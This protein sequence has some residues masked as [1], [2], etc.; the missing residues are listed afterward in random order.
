MRGV[1]AIL[2]LLLG[3]ALLAVVPTPTRAGG[4][5]A[6]R[7]VSYSYAA[8]VQVAYSYAAPIKAV[9]AYVSPDYA[10]T[11]YSSVDSAYQQ[12]LLVDAVAGR[13]VELSKLQ[14]ELSAL[15]QQLAGQYQPQQ[16]PQPYA[17]QQ[18]PYAPSQQHYAPPQA[19]PSQA[20]PYQPHDYPPRQPEAPR[21]PDYSR[22]PAAPESPR[23][24]YQGSVPQGLGEIVQSACLRCHGATAE[25]DGVGIDLR[26]L[27]AVDEYTRLLCVNECRTQRMPRRAAA[28][29]EEQI[30]L[31]EQWHQMARQARTARR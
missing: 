16:Q 19:P 15:R 12:K 6:P 14:A 8:P 18:Q 21:Q 9:K 20:P 24:D 7:A 10:P 2:S 23:G 5:C 27:G 11:Y 1:Y 29:S 25:K 17:P 22:P 26:N 13:V 28:L 30:A 4:I 3:T 31:F